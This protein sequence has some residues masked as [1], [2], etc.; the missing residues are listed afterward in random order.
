MQDLPE[1]VFSSPKRFLVFKFILGDLWVM[2]VVSDFE[3]STK[4]ATHLCLV[5]VLPVRQRRGD[6]PGLRHGELDPGA[7]QPSLPGPGLASPA[8][9]VVYCINF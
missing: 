9:G 4:I 8:D 3:I 2:S 7:G 6:L 5:Q 1:L